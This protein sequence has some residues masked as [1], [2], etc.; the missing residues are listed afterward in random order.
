MIITTA[1]DMI[2]R[3]RPS[4]SPIKRMNTAPT[5]HPI[6]YIAVTKPC[7]VELSLVSGMAAL[8]SGEVMM[9]DISPR[10]AIISSGFWA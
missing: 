4:L 1:P 9:P 5:K 8:N 2:E 7:I 6:S 10:G 3:L